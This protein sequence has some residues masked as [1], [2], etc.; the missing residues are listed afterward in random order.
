MPTGTPV[1]YIP[2][3]TPTTTV[4]TGTPVTYMP[5]GTPVTYI[6]TGTPVT[7]M[8]T[9]TPVT[10]SKGPT[11]CYDDMETIQPHSEKA[12]SQKMTTDELF[13]I[14]PSAEKEQIVEIEVTGDD[15]PSIL[16]PS[17]DLLTGT[18][19]NPEDRKALILD[20]GEKKFIP[21][22]YFINVMTKLGPIVNDLDVW[23]IKSTHGNNVLVTVFNPVSTKNYAEILGDEN[24]LYDVAESTTPTYIP[25]TTVPTGTP[26]TSMPTGTPVTYMP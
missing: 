9:G 6:P 14:S 21:S 12:L 17:A 18:T 26:V 3:G 24:P 5:T 7:Y 25:T 1:T 19:L 10:S 22:T 16:I 20:L 23:I 2:T 15:K 8:P 11:I 13:E 4:P